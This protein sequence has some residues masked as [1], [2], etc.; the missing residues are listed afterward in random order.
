MAEEIYRDGLDNVKQRL[1]QDLIGGHMRTCADKSRTRIKN[2]GGVFK[3][4]FNQSKG[5]SLYLEESVH[6]FS[7][8]L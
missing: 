6:L 4:I 8:Q 3:Q 5:R 1:F 2:A 7:D